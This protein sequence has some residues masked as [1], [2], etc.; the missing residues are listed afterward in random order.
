MGHVG[1]VDIARYRVYGCRCRR[2]NGGEEVRADHRLRI[3]DVHEA[4]DDPHEAQA[5]KNWPNPELI[6]SPNDVQLKSKM[7]LHSH[8][9]ID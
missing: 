5:L 1:A 8:V 6:S 3:P 9:D 7:F 2:V 4:H